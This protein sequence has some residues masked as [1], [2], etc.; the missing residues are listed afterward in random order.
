MC[1]RELGGL[2]LDRGA[3][4]EVGVLAEQQPGGPSVGR[5]G[6]RALDD[7]RLVV[8]LTSFCP[9]SMIELSTAREPIKQR[10]G[11]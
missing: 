2:P 10:L 3:D 4:E 7:D 8:V 6:E 9:V 11:R 5:F 1:V